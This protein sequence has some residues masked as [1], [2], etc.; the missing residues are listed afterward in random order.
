MPLA[1]QNIP[2]EEQY[3]LA[4]EQAGPVEATRVAAKIAARVVAF[5]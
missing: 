2:A 4:V 3:M 1:A 5:D